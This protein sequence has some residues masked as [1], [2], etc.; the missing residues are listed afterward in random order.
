M[1]AIAPGVA[2]G[3]DLLWFAGDMFGLAIFNV[4]AG[5]GPL[6]VGVKANAVR[7]IE[8]NTLHLAAQ[9][10]AFGQRGHHL[11]AVA[12]NH[13]VGPVRLMPIK[14][15]P[16]GRAGQAVKVGK[17]IGHKAGV[18]FCRLGLPRLALTPEVVNQGPGLHL[19]LNIKRRRVRHQF[20]P[21]LLILAPP[22]Q[23]RIEIANPL[24]FLLA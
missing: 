3:L 18:L 5:G 23:L 16:G 15:G 14:L 11:Q 2:K 6:K 1:N 13:A 4:A 8:V 9:A 10:L 24:V 12:Q 22:D 20:R 7:G 17:Q 21:V 19:L